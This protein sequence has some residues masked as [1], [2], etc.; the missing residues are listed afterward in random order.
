MVGVNS[1]Y[2]QNQI[3]FRTQNSD[4]KIIMQKHCVI[5]SLP[6][7][8]SRAI[9]RTDWSSSSSCG[10]A[11]LAQRTMTTGRTIAMRAMVSSTVANRT[12][13]A[14]LIGNDCIALKLLKS[15]HS[16]QHAGQAAS[17]AKNLAKERIDRK[18]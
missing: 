13:T 1:D 5:P 14:C 15:G 12:S 8:I 2:T 16:A 18:S 6:I 17:S 11:R 3:E 9:Q 10:C 4:R 7:P